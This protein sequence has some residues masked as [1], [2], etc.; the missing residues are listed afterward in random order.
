MS[1]IRIYHNGHILTMDAAASVASAVAEKDGRIVAVGPAAEALS[2]QNAEKIDLNGK[3]MLP[4]FIDGH[5]HFTTAGLMEATQ[6]NL[7]SP[8]VGTVKNFSEIGDLLRRK[9]ASTPKGGWILCYG[10][11]DTALDERRHPTAADLDKAAPDHNVVLRHVSGHLSVCNSLALKTSGYTRE[12]ADP[13]GG[14]IR[15]DA[16]GNPNGVLEEPPARELLFAHIPPVTKEDWEAAIT[17]ACDMYAA[18]GVTTAQD[19]FTDQAIWD[20]LFATHEAGNLKIRVQV[21]PGIG[22]MSFDCIPAVKSGTPL[23]ADDMLI[24]GPAKMLADGSL[25]CYTGYLSNP[26]HKILPGVPYDSLWRGYPIHQEGDFSRTVSEYHRKGWQLAIHGNGDDAIQ[27]IINAYARAQ[28]EHPREDARH[29]VI[30]CQTVR[31]DQLDRMAANGISASFF[32]VHTYFWG[33]RHRD[34]F[35]GEDRA[36]RIDPLRSAV[37]RGIRFS[38]HND[39][40]V[41]PIDPLLSVWSAATRRTGSGAV[42]G[43]DQTISVAEGLRAVTSDAAW[44]AH[45][46][47]RIGS[48]EVG[49][50]ADFAILNANPLAMPVE[51]VRDI[52]VVATIAGGQV[53]H[54]NPEQ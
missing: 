4:G 39:T 47:D 5:S 48:I 14:I 10:Y 13:P 40:F 9:A 11:D 49:K 37:N 20:A 53:V 19:G 24:L 27:M 7:A 29:F 8:P 43:A 34:I 1:R 12:M 16:S 36:R 44:L 28:A 35:L 46:E 2:D 38:L 15:R 50:M 51:E 23:T 6:I 52:E 33:D 41:T 18:K 25:Q 30:H 21:L 54:G 26:Y 3:T 42:L 45:M 22:R 32:V 17:T 31:E